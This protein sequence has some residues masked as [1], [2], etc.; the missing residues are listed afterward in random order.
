MDGGLPVER[1]N[2]RS[3]VRCVASNGNL[4]VICKKKREKFVSFARCIFKS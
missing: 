1:V 4:N 2:D 3:P